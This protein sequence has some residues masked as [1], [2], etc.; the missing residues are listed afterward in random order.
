[1]DSNSLD[2]LLGPVA[3]QRFRESH[4]E[5]RF[6]HITRSSQGFYHDLLTFEQ[7]DILA[8]LAIFQQLPS[9]RLVRSSNGRIEHGSISDTPDSTPP[10]IALYEHYADGYSVLVNRL[11]HIWP[12]VAELCL[13]LQNELTHPVGANLYLTP[14]NSQCFE[15]HFDAHDVFVLQIHGSKTWRMFETPVELPLEGDSLRNYAAFNQTCFSE[16]ILSA[17]DLLYIP[18]GLVHEAR[19]TATSSLHLTVGVYVLRRLDVVREALERVAKDVRPLRE[20]VGV[21]SLDNPDH[22]CCPDAR[23]Q[24]LSRLRNILDDQVAVKA[25]QKD[26][27]N[28]KH[29]LLPPHF[30]ELDELTS[31]TLQTRLRMREGVVCKVSKSREGSEIRFRGNWVRGP[32]F[33][34]RALEYVSETK[35]FT[36]A[37]LPNSLTDEGKLTLARRLVRSGLLLF[38]EAD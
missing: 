17:G 3:T 21:G 24:I 35:E 4:W 18:R 29:S 28:R 12:S 34:H 2:W 26:L 16:V 37:E 6:L 30:S 11:H 15:P 14:A 1:M 25:I 8:R 10:I 31:M 20:S 19:S 33:V 13:G 7:L 38:S 32:E 9:V 5:Q 23:D 22:A 27:V 36:V